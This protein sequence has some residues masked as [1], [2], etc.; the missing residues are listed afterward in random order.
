M[1]REKKKKKKRCGGLG[2]GLGFRQ[3]F[4]WKQHADGEMASEESKETLHAGASLQRVYTACRRDSK[5]C[6]R[7]HVARTVFTDRLEDYGL[8]AL[9]G[10]D[11]CHTCLSSGAS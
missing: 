3:A 8:L 6:M 10:E 7:C 9:G 2:D 5:C 1:R 11:H 4:F